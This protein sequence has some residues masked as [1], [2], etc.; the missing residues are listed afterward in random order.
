MEV[1]PKANAAQEPAKQDATPSPQEA[2]ERKKSRLYTRTGD[3]GA[4]ALFTGERRDKDDDVFE[5]L[6]TVDE[7]S[8]FIGVALQFAMAE[9]GVEL[10]LGRRSKVCAF[11]HDTLKN[12][13]SVGTIVA[14]P[15]RPELH[16]E[17][18]ARAKMDVLEKFHPA[19]WISRT[20]ALIDELDAQLPKLTTFILPGGGLAATHLHVCRSVCR[21]A[22]RSLVRAKNSATPQSYGEPFNIAIIY[23][24]RLSDFFFVAARTFATT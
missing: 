13:L 9:T 19:E 24:N 3:S 18:A 15:Y 1:P 21:R 22:E 8:S 10:E 12:L 6:G 20:E 11:L 16:G 5:A 4:S 7:L 2:V 23:M 17:A 14:T